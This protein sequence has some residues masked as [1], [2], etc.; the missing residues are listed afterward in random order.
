VSRWAVYEI[1]EAGVLVYV[2]TARDPD[3]RL[4][5]HKSRGKAAR[6]ATV[7]V[8]QWFDHAGDALDFEAKH[9]FEAKP[10]RNGHHNCRGA[11]GRSRMPTE[12][13]FK[14]W[15]GSQW[16]TAGEVLKMMPGWTNG[17]ARYHFGLR[18]H[19]YG[20]VSATVR[21]KNGLPIL[22]PTEQH[23]EA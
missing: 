23:E 15:H 17:M 6:H 16:Q 11:C 3:R 21:T 12:A 4:Y 13:A 14:I 20:N 8:V 22:D 18:G 9:I 7:R 5:Y 1:L 19:P 10:P 2:G